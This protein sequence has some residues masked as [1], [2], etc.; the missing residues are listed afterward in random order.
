MTAKRK[1]ITVIIFENSTVN[2]IYCQ[3][4]ESELWLDMKILNGRLS[5]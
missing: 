5:S 2:Q 1:L 3:S 4:Y